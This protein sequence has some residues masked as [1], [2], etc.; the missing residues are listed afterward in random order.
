VLSGEALIRLVFVARSFVLCSFHANSGCSHETLQH[1]TTA[2][3]LTVAC[4]DQYISRL[5]CQF[6]LLNTCACWL[7]RQTYL[8]LPFNFS[9][10]ICEIYW[11]TCLRL[12]SLVR[13]SLEPALHYFERIFS[14]TLTIVVIAPHILSLPTAPHISTSCGVRLPGNRFIQL[15]K[16]FDI[17]GS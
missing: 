4:F 6:G 3:Q 16:L 11:S 12:A 8:V 5:F 7:R 1:H 10:F 9:I 13:S 14:F 2:K 15:R 17:A